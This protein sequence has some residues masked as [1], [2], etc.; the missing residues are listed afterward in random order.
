MHQILRMS[1]C[2][3]TT[4]NE[5]K[6]LNDFFPLLPDQSKPFTYYSSH[7]FLRLTIVLQR[8]FLVIHTSPPPPHYSS[9]VDITHVFIQHT[10]Y[11]MVGEC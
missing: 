9:R 2:N 5:K 1:F 7:L 11:R 3:P 10:I 6:K 8:S 4:I